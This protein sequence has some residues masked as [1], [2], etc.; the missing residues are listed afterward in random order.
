MRFLEKKAALRK[1]RTFWRKITL[2]LFIL[3]V[4]F[5]IYMTIT[6]NKLKIE[7]KVDADIPTPI[8]E[9]IPDR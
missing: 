2:I 4:F 8:H 7:H 1:Q 6:I 3:C 9:F 5:A